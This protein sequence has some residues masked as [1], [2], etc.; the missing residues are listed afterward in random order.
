MPERDMDTL[1]TLWQQ[2]SNG[3]FGFVQQRKI[4]RKVRGQFDKFAEA[5][6]WFTATW[7]CIDGQAGFYYQIYQD[8]LV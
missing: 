5:V 8:I 3:K 1:E 4:W 7:I 6:S 2:N